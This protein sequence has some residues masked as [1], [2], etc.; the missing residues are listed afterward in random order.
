MPEQS[1]FLP[2]CKKIWDHLC[3]L[4]TTHKKD[5]R[6]HTAIIAKLTE[7]NGLAH[8]RICARRYISISRL[9]HQI[10]I[11]FGISK[12][13]S[14]RLAYESAIVF[15]ARREKFLPEKTSYKK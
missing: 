2:F 14:S 12:S 15:F 13:S 8:L 3:P 6:E 1:S 4:P 11:P 5:L 10:E 9:R 7:T